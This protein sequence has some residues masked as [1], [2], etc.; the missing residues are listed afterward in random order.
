MGLRK[1]IKIAQATGKPL[2]ADA[3]PRT[4]VGTEQRYV[5]IPDGPKAGPLIPKRIVATLAA[6]TLIL[7]LAYSPVPKLKREVKH[8]GSANTIR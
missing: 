1:R 5:R 4:E 6:V 2:P 8:V 7:V 3:P